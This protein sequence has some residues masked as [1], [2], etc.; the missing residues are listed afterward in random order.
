MEKKEKS[1]DP[2][3]ILPDGYGVI[4]ESIKKKVK[5]AQLRALSAV[6]K[7]LISLY[8]EIGKTIHEQQQADSWGTSVVEQFAKDLQNSFPGEYSYNIGAIV[9][10][11][12]GCPFL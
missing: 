4:L 5:E 9:P 12:L 7:E 2:L 3:N 10:K 6:N 8:W 11:T 1:P